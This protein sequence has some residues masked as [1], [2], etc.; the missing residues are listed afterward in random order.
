MNLLSKRFTELLAEG[1]VI[2]AAHTMEYSEFWQKQKPQVDGNKVLAWQLKAI[3]AIEKAA[4]VNSTH[5]RHFEE[6][7]KHNYDTDF[8]RLQRQRA[9]LD[10]V[11]D[12]YDGGYLSSARS[13]ARAEVF[14]TEL[15]LAQ[16]L[17]RQA[18]KLPSAVVARTVLET[19][20]RGLCD[21]HG[22]PVGKL[23]A[24]NASLAKQQVYSVMVQKKVTWLADIG[25]S[26]AHGKPEKFSE[27]D[28]AEMIDGV[29]KF[30]ADFPNA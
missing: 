8:D 14:D 28:V 25:N 5:T 20:L 17:L 21:L 3:N 19:A 2:L 15:E 23:D 16:E 27:Q 7:G 1:N 30:I 9:V 13:L 12:D 6:A 29:T 22:L 11:K 26:A 4:G 24:M 10:A 18:Y